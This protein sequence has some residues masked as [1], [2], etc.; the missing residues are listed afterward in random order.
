MSVPFTVIALYSYPLADQEAAEDDL[1]FNAKQLITV[2]SV[3]DD[4]W[5]GGSYTDSNGQYRSGFFPQSFVKIHAEPTQTSAPIPVEPTKSSTVSAPEPISSPIA[6]TTIPEPVAAAEEPPSPQPIATPTPVKNTTSQSPVEEK[7]RHLKETKTDL[8]ESIIKDEK[9]SPSKL[10]EH[11]DSNFKNKLKAFNVSAEPP[12]PGHMSVDDR[13][14]KKKPFSSPDA[15]R[16]SYIPPMFG[17]NNEKKHELKQPAPTNVVS[18]NS[19]ANETEEDAAPR[20]TLKQRM[21]LL[22]EQRKKEEEA[23]A[24]AEQRKLEKKK[25][26]K[27]RTTETHGESP[28]ET[29]HTGHSIS[30]NNT[31]STQLTEATEGYQQSIEG[32]SLQQEI[33]N[34]SAQS[35]EPVYEEEENEDEEKEDANEVEEE[36][37]EEDDKDV[38]DEDEDDEEGDEDDEEDEEDEEELKKRQLRERMAKLSGGMGMMGM[39]GGVGFGLPGM[40][41]P[42]KATKP[43]KKTVKKSNTNTEESEEMANLPKAIPVLPF[44]NPQALPGLAS[45]LGKKPMDDESEEEDEEEKK[46]EDDDDEEEE[47][48]KKDEDD[49]DEEE[50]KVD[51]EFTHP[52]SPHAPKIPEATPIATENTDIKHNH[53]YRHISFSETEPVSD[54]R[55]IDADEEDF[56][57]E[58]GHE[59]FAMPHAPPPKSLSSSIDGDSSSDE[60][61]I[62]SKD[63]NEATQLNN[64]SPVQKELGDDRFPDS[65]HIIPINRPTAQPTG[66]E[67]EDEFTDRNSSLMGSPVRPAEPTLYSPQRVTNSNAAHTTTGLERRTGPIP[68]ESTTITS[69]TKLPPPP[70]PFSAVPPIPGSAPPIPGSAPPIPGSAPPIPSAAPPIPGQAP[71]IPAPT[72]VG[73]IPPI[74]RV[75][76]GPEHTNHHGP[77]S[78]PPPPPPTGA[79]PPVPR[80]ATVHSESRRP[81]TNS[82]KRAST[83]YPQQHAPPPIPSQ[84]APP[85]PFQEPP[86]HHT[87]PPPPPPSA[88]APP[89]PV[90]AVPGDNILAQ[91]SGPDALYKSINTN[92]TQSSGRMNSPFE[93][94]R[95][96]RSSM[97]VSRT[98]PSVNSESFSQGLRLSEYVQGNYGDWWVS[99]K[100]PGDSKFKDV[101][102]EIN[103]FSQEKRCSRSVLYIDYYILNKDYSQIIWEISCD[104]NHPE[105]IL[106]YSETLLPTPSASQEYL[107]KASSTYGP[108]II[109]LTKSAQRTSLKQEFISWIFDQLPPKVLRNVGKSY[110]TVIYRNI[111]NKDVRNYDKIRPGDIF[112]AVHAKFESRSALHKKSVEL[113]T[114][115]QPHMAVITEFDKIKNKFRV[116]EQDPR[117]VVQESSYKLS[118][119]KSGRIEV[120]RVVGRNYVGW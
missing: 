84:Q 113:G 85:I 110:G 111:D 53:P 41:A 17:T 23:I 67:A 103:S 43:K 66:Y 97:E 3:P 76:T 89:A 25:K 31:G 114:S 109:E 29:T 8:E 12:L 60:T 75:P 88:P 49:E 101:L 52:A 99:R 91:T 9:F 35:T 108:K 46:E 55:G 48:P 14:N 118:D 73:T 83:S 80:A 26:L 57:P 40:G 102:F 69:P 4:D 11:I 56:E 27:K 15:H 58:S 32:A 5:Y 62:D 104:A 42:P 93:D 81:S 116:V 6:T 44:A 82:I 24:A 50:S 115:R 51:D 96:G 2:S 33:S 28:L 70:P 112:S 20:M 117:G 105:N 63:I 61:P 71:S 22:E 95:I 98:S 16:S 100:L 7:F 106:S 94:P 120:F 92:D 86:H 68:Q 78:A 77:G 13:Y 21:Q 119:M 38:N 47:E 18:E 72:P 79:A 30:T 87:A 36:E 64:T 37:E 90:P 1:P 65:S 74:P 45:Q 54:H 34:E 19:P 59:S 10:P 39:M 107:K